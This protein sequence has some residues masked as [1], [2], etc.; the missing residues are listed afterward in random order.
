MLD[1][2]LR[3][4]DAVFAAVQRVVTGRRV[5]RFTDVVRMRAALGDAGLPA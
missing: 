5:H 3:T 2:L 1:G 4:F